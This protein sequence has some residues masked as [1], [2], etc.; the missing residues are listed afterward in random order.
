M[1]IGVIGHTGMVGGAVYRYFQNQKMTVYGHSPSEPNEKAFLAEVIFVCVPTPYHWDGRG[2]DE[3]IVREVFSKILT[4]A[5]VVLKSTVQ[6][7]TT[8]KL[9][10]EYPNLNILF[11][12]EFL[13][14]ATCDAD[15]QNP[16]RQYVGYTEKSHVY[17]IQVLNLLPE[18]AFG[19]LVP[20]KEAE[21]LKYINNMHG[22]LSVIEANHYFDVCAK[23]GL[24]Y[25]RVIHAAE[26]SKWVGAP[27]S[28]QYHKIYH[29]GYRGV[30]GACFPKD[31][32]AWIDYCEKNGVDVSL[33]KAARDYNK[34][35]LEK[36]GMTEADAE[37]HK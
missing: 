36:Q 9:Q 33:L 27:M 2:Y 37:K 5:I 25:D 10:A 15:F 7:G 34:R 19:V 20:A 4:R 18:S 3:T 8:D 30:G 21:L 26:A 17:G 32:N 14:E 35:I 31:L 23:E 22:V 28:R 13:S 16:D 1:T 24:D 6:I 11:N 29:K 12:P